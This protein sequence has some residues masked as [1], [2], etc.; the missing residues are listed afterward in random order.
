[1][2]ISPE[3]WERVKSLY[4]AVLES[5]PTERTEFL[6][7]SEEDELVRQ[8][9]VRLLQEH[10]RVGSFLSVPAFVGRVLIDTPVERPP[11]FPAGQILA[12]RFRIVGFIAA[13]GMGEVYRAEDI[14]LDR[15][16]VLKFL[17]QELA[18]DR[19]SL[20][21]LRHEARAAS[22]LNHPNICTVY[23]FGEDD[24]RAFIAMEYLEGET[25]SARIKQGP[26]SPQEALPIALAMAA[27]LE[28]AHAKGIVH[29]DLKPGNIMLTSTGPK[30]LDF[31]LA[32]YEKPGLVSEGLSG[33]EEL[34]G[35]LP[36]MS[37]ERL[38]GA[39]SGIRGDIF[40]FG[41]V[42]YEMLAGC[43]AFEGR[44]RAEIIAAVER[45]EPKPL[46]EVVK[47]LPDG[48]ED[49]VR[50]CLQKCP[51][52][53][54]DSLSEIRTE[55][56]RGAAALQTRSALT[57]KILLRRSMRPRVV[58][59]L[60]LVLLAVTVLCARIVQR[61][62]RG[63]W[64]RN[65][66]LPQISTLIEQEK[67]GE[68]YALA[69]EAA[70]YIP[71]DP[72]LARFWS[73]ISWS[74]SITTNPA[75]VSVYRRP[76]NS[77]Q[78]PWEFVG[79]TPIANR[80]FPLVDSQWKFEREGF[81]TVERATFPDDSLDV[82]MEEQA[83]VPPGMVR[84]WLAT[85]KSH[86]EPVGLYGFSGYEGVQAVPL[87]DYWIDKFEVTNAQFKQF[88]D[89]GGYQNP[90][91][92]D[93]VFWKDGHALL[94]TEAMKL[95]VDRTGRPGPATWTAGE[96]PKGQE[97]YP[98]TG[99]SW[100]EAAAY[101]N[102][103]GKSLP[104]MYHWKAAASP[105]NGPSMVPA[106]NFAASGAA[107]VGSYGGM[108]WSGTYDMAGNVK[109]WVWNEATP[110]IHYILG[111]AWDE[112]AHMFF[113][114]DA[115]SPFERAANF[116][117]RCAKYSLTG[118]AARAA[119]PITLQARDFSREKP[120]SPDTFKVYKGFYSYEKTPMHAQVLS[121]REAQD[122]TEE[123][124]AFDAAYGNER[125]VAHLFLPR[126]T[127]PPY[128]TVLYFPGASALFETS[129]DNQ[130]QLEQFDF[131]IKSGRAVMFPV[132]KGTFERGDNFVVFRSDNS[133]YRDH[134]IQWSKDL[135][136][137][138]D[139]LETRTDIDHHKLAYEGVSWGA[140]M[141]AVLP[142]VE[143]R[144]KAVVLVCPGF[145]L[146][147]RSP[148]A[149]QINFAPQ[150]TAPVLMLNGRFDFLFPT[151]SSQEPMF[152]LLGTPKKDKR[153]VLYDTGHDI[154]REE[155]IKETLNWLDRYLGP[156]R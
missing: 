35:T 104:T 139:Y 156:V 92:W 76:Y 77:P 34:G 135:G 84:I 18:E 28:T 152:R 94:W 151:G 141:G 38:Q 30:L 105:V 148:E 6:H 26:I 31:G 72:M 144:I 16:V 70:R 8:E 140:A 10:D 45:A 134:V 90:K 7:Q 14:L 118:Q 129:S 117:F 58:V 32:K 29:R 153:R 40:A 55:L 44:S 74:G 13:G 65:E 24:G 108:S 122:W 80:R 114:P 100:F 39:S 9:V 4:E 81:A 147:K 43:R 85:P 20:E 73:D 64:A 109:E 132:Y 49:V 3:Q 121:V 124:I 131:V 127:P 89:Q 155:M 79:R 67:L 53:R 42:L 62:A 75:G 25:L 111:G 51:D 46:R 50:R 103:A 33:D 119:E 71:D 107:A 22:I 2:K 145:Y 88:V 137:S 98:V 21:R 47:N 23:D 52:E 146:Q 82:T 60:L 12:K 27:A 143:Q 57:L 48:A 149:D 138:I 142:A 102:F 97:N 128:Q 116:G 83:K 99:V 113:N 123:K 69:V 150:V 54:F 120:V 56:Q 5:T 11:R 136:R 115:R 96:Y 41:A 68:A 93:Q 106:S 126:K 59:P 1:M 86:V 36:Y 95:F 154:P 61:N 112:P 110:G 125:L 19:V 66:A 17:S 101:A 91:F 63:R 37:P 87:N 78:S 130:P 133:S 15:T